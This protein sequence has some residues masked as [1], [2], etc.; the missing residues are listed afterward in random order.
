[1][2]EKQ[3]DS[4]KKNSNKNHMKTRNMRKHP[5]NVE[6]RKVPRTSRTIHVITHYEGI[7]CKSGENFK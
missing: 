3:L 1:M 7:N 2:K 5:N 6:R 4:K